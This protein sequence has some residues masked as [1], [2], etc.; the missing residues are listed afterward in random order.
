MRGAQG[1]SHRDVTLIHYRVTTSSTFRDNSM[2]DQGKRIGVSYLRLILPS[3]SLRRLHRPAPALMSWQNQRQTGPGGC[4]CACG[5]GRPP[6]MDGTR[7]SEKT[8]WES[9]SWSSCPPYASSHPVR[10]VG[11]RRSCGVLNHLSTQ[12]SATRHLAFISMGWSC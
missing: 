3:G 6:R 7:A 8:N 4:I 10:G 9:V 1:P 2:P 5:G 11:S 12:V